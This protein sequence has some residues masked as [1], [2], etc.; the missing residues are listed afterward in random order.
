MPTSS[1]VVTTVHGLRLRVGKI[2]VRLCDQDTGSRGNL[3][4][5]LR[6]VALEQG[7]GE[8]KALS[9]KGKKA[10][11]FS[12]SRSGHRSES[13]SA[14]SAG[15][16]KGE[17][18]EN[19][20]FVG[21]DGVG[22]RGHGGEE[23]VSERGRL[24]SGSYTSRIDGA[25]E[26]GDR[27]IGSR[28]TV[29]DDEGVSRLK[30]GS[31]ARA[32][33]V[34][35]RGLRNVEISDG[36]SSDKS[37]NNHHYNG[38]TDGYSSI[39][40]NDNLDMKVLRGST[41]GEVQGTL[42]RTGELSFV[43]DGLDL[44]AA[45]D[46]SRDSTQVDDPES[47]KPLARG[48]SAQ[49]PWAIRGGVP[50]DLNLLPG[51][52]LDGV[53]ASLGEGSGDEEGKT[54]EGSPSNLGRGEVEGLRCVVVGSDDSAEEGVAE[55]SETVS[56]GIDQGEVE[57]RESDDILA[58]HRKVGS[59]TWNKRL[60]AITQAAW[61]GSKQA[62]CRGFN[63]NASSASAAS[64]SSNSIAGGPTGSTS[65]A[66]HRSLSRGEPY[67]SAGGRNS[68]TS[69]KVA[70]PALPPR[71]E[72]RKTS[73]DSSLPSSTSPSAVIGEETAVE[74]G[75][76]VKSRVGGDRQPVRENETGR[77][78]SGTGEKK[79]AALGDRVA[80]SGFLYRVVLDGLNAL[81]TL[82]IR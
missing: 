59:G 5:R 66:S 57:E 22:C 82:R 80:G 9:P 43:T 73:G 20:A 26:D 25:S 3:F 58:S 79:G 42:S 65:N 81:I 31:A 16:G 70:P 38:F 75:A 50:P 71:P 10:R 24:S 34:R 19:R 52:A 55:I 68:S 23:V 41:L 54:S 8:T 56:S 62:S 1:L 36:S 44:T 46:G 40:D 15:T 61:L 72:P 69:Q 48:T 63:S 76:S 17:S 37:D 13:P 60:D 6:R 45:T 32:D 51:E 18:Y 74:G 7:C 4:L 53:L 39:D 21:V 78:S 12:R 14:A 35:G 30:T 28:G 47:R 27:G 49:S 11:G 2:E 67:S 77:G 29:L 33:R 64:S